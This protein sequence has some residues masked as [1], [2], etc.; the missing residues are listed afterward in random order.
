MTEAIEVTATARLHLGFLDL[1]G[2]LGRRFGSLGLSLDQP[3]TRLRL[4]AAARSRFEGPESERAAQHLATLSQHLG[5]T[6]GHQLRIEEAI[7]AHAGLGSGTQLALAV[8]TSVRWLHGL[9]LDPRADALLLGRGARSGVGIGLFQDGGLVL[10]GGRGA[11]EPPPPL[12]A[13][14]PLPRPWRVLLLL[15]PA[16]QGLSGAR[17]RAAF[18]ALPPLDEAVCAELCRLVL[19]QVLPAVAESDLAAFGAAVTQM[20][21]ILGDYFAPAQ[22]ARITSRRVADGLAALA[23]RGACGIGQSSWGPTGFAFIANEPDAQREAAALR[24]QPAGAGLD[25]LV[26]RGLNRGATVTAL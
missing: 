24:A 16:H 22:G 1:N 6:R 14:L 19:M 21:D 18:A 2:S 15:D 4:A 13:R 7:P 10:D 9:R 23:A 25:I 26:C 11:A 20:Q 12:L 3:R 17:E 5:L 8:A